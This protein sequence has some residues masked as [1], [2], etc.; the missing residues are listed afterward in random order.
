MKEII[1]VENIVHR[2]GAKL[3]LNG[4][5]F[6]VYEGEVFGLLGPNGVGKTTTIRLL[7]GLLNPSSGKMTVL[8]FDPQKQGVEIRSR[9][10]VLTETPALYERLTA[11]ENLRFFGS[12]AGMTPSYCKDRIA[13][14][15]EFFNLTERTND[16]VGSYSKGMKQ[17]L[18]LARALLIKP[19]LLFLDEPTTGLDPEVARQ[20]HDLIM[21]VRL[22]DGHTVVLCTHHLYEAERLCDR[23]AVMG[24]GKLITMGT[25]EQLRAEAA[26]EH[27]TL[28]SFLSPISA[29]VL[30]T[31][32]KHTGVEKIEEKGPCGLLIQINNNAIIPDLINL[33]VK[34]GS[35][36]VAVEPQQASLEE[37]YFRLQQRAEENIQ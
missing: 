30:S 5:S 25:L 11:M 28:F 21:E 35:S 14:L 26:P 8:G 20:V 10:G 34:K 1:Q 19:E 27:K 13:E 12:L 33:L 32:K 4:I 3:A 9:V 7:N 18:A 31:L 37:I 15:L 6:N 2:Y 29:D 22:K 16:R 23:M 36:I 24:K 17:R